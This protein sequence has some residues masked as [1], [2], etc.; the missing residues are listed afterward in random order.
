MG[1]SL[2]HKKPAPNFGKFQIIAEFFWGLS[3]VALYQGKVRCKGKIDSGFASILPVLDL[4]SSKGS[5]TS[6]NPTCFRKFEDP[7]ECPK[8]GGS[9]RIVVFLSN[10][11][12]IFLGR[13]DF[14]WSKLAGKRWRPI[15][16]FWRSWRKVPRWCWCA[17][18]W[19]K[20]WLVS[21]ARNWPSAA[22]L[23]GSASCPR[24]LE[25]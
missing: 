24:S 10:H 25:K 3:V 5:T 13:R 18:L 22:A 19:V 14:F 6:C 21:S 20:R 16:V 11:L 1:S 23:S 4:N 17:V 9:P 7:K 12:I 8:I 2:N 15:Q